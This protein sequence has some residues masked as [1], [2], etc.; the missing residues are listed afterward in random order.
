M[1]EKLKSKI[2]IKTLHIYRQEKI[3]RKKNH[4]AT[5]PYAT[6]EFCKKKSVK[7]SSSRNCNGSICKFL[8]LP[9]GAMHLFPPSRP[10]TRLFVAQNEKKKHSRV[11]TLYCSD[12][13]GDPA[14]QA[15]PRAVSHTGSTS[16]LVWLA[17][18]VAL[19][20]HGKLGFPPPR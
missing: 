10:K 2:L 9:N 19:Y 18:R 15:L 17:L 14:R 6:V 12:T 3:I 7:I 8:F 13:R 20:R 11:R 4:S 16:C 5:A 1:G